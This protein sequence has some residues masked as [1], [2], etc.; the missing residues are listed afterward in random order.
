MQELAC[1]LSTLDARRLM[2][3]GLALAMV[4][5]GIVVMFWVI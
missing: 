5:G 4:V 2:A 3:D 1:L